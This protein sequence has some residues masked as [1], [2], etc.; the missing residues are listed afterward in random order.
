MNSEFHVV[1]KTS[2]GGTGNVA[3]ELA[4]FLDIKGIAR[5]KVIRAL[6]PLVGL[7]TATET[8]DLC[9]EVTI[10]AVT[11]LTEEDVECLNTLGVTLKYPPFQSACKALGGC[12][13]M[14]GTDPLCCGNCRA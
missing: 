6:Q 5:I 7:R 12:G 13:M 8:V 11:N 1:N 14:N 3:G 2:V 10:I 4:T 9:Q